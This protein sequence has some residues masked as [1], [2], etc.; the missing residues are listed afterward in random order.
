MGIAHTIIRKPL[1]HIV[2]KAH[3]YLSNSDIYMKTCSYLQ[4]D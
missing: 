1:N 3:N 4:A 2:L